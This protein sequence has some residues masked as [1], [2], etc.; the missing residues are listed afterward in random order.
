MIQKISKEIEAYKTQTVE[1][2]EGISGYSQAKIVRR[3]ML[4]KTET[5]PRG[6]TD[7]QGNYKYWFNIIK[8]RVSSEVKNIDFDTKD[9]LLYSD[10]RKDG[11]RV[12]ISNAALKEWLQE[13]GQAEKLNEAVERGSEWGNVVWK[14]IKNDYRILDLNN[15]Y[16]LN[17][18]AFSLEDSDVIE[19][20]TMLATDLRKKAD[21]WSNVEDLIKTAKPDDK[22]TSPE[23]FIYERNGEISE[24][25]YYDAVNLKEGKQPGNPGKEDKYMLAKVI[26]GG[27]DKDKPTHVLFCEEITEKPYKE[28]H[29]SSY[30]GRWLRVGLYETLFD[31]QTR[32][33]EIGN[34]I[35]RGLEWASKTV[36]RSSDRVI[37]QN[38]L[39]DLQNGD[40]IKSSDLQQVQTRMEGLD[41]LI[42]DWNRLMTLADQLAN[43]YEV[44][45][46]EALPA[47]TPFSL[48]QLLNTNAAKLF[49]FIR[50]KLG[51]AFQDVIEEWIL[52]N[53]L[54]DLKAKDVLRLTADNSALNEYYKAVVDDWYVRNLI[55]F[56]PHSPEEAELIK[57]EK[58]QELL[59]KKEVMVDLEKDMWQGFKPRVRVIITGENFNIASELETLKTFIQFEQDP[60]R[61]SALIELAMSKKGLD[62]TTLPKTPLQSLNQPKPTGAA[63]E[64]GEVS[65]LDTALKA[66]SKALSQ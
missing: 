18:T 12:L 38:I 52:P 24:K 39:T 28:Y 22:K 60:M 2:I 25:E 20:E 13:T 4:Y 56:P 44:I 61:R 7:S 31:I 57:E 65:A 23:F 45:A 21:I 16:V 49:D 37:A 17:Q 27:I 50:E 30:S 59:K 35:A 34:Q 15:L 41:Q 48:G 3:I 58:L 19:W 14:K 66:Q 8:P 26:V 51:I 33:N 47:G 46:G 32:A 54:K 64:S 55:S 62:I 42:A 63:E 36:F 40:I 10:A 43:S 11:L 6:K 9:I 29:R 1:I 53:V 5:Y